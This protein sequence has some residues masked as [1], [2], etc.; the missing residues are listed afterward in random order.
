MNAITR[1]SDSMIKHQEATIR[2]QEEKSDSR[3][4]A[5]R[6]L[7]KITQNII[8]LSGVDENGE[9]PPTPTDDMYSIL[10]CQ[11]GAQ[12]NQYLKQAMPSHNV[13]FEPGFCTALNKG[14]FLSPD[15]VGTP[16]NFTPFLMPPTADDDDEE[17]NA[18]LLKLAVQEKYDRTDIELL[19]KMEVSIPMKSQELRHYLK[20]IAEVAGRCM[21]SDSV[22]YS[23]LMSLYNHI[24]RH[25]MSYNF[26]FKNDKLFGG[27]FLDRIHYRIQRFLESCAS[28]DAGNI[29]TKHLQFEEMLDSI[30]RR[31]YYAKSPIW[32]TKLLKKRADGPK[33]IGD[34]SNKRRSQGYGHSGQNSDDRK[35][36]RF[37][38]Q[39]QSKKITNDNICQ[40]CR[41]SS[42]EPFREMFHPGNIRTLKKPENNGV[43]LCMRY[44]T[45]GYCFSD[46]KYK[47]GHGVLGAAEAAMKTFVAQAR[48]NLPH[49]RRHGNRNGR[50][51][52]HPSTSNTTPTGEIPEIE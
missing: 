10:G 44:H 40:D 50:E 14:M 11:N 4:K 21:G 52:H 7:P 19:T 35:R 31:E 34:E 46:C 23:A 12:V 45:L 28:G 33:K 32:L 47:S 27:N 22:L 26:E 49:F 29:N 17:Q 30:E 39:D 24:E 43:M 42:N 41:L 5:W 20:N 8:L 9:V 1:L 18:N 3:F 16:S 36:R 48:A 25:D 38:P 37:Q 51:Q 15:G 13:S 2:N 6:R